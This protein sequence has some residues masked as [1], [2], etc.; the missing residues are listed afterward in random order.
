MIPMEDEY[1]EKMFLGQIENPIAASGL[2]LTQAE[3]I[4][5]QMVEYK[6]MRMMY[7]CALKE[8]RTKFDV[9]NTEFGVRYQRNPIEFIT[10]RVKS[11]HS[12]FEKMRRQNQTFTMNSLEENISDIAGIR[13]IC[14]YVDDIYMLAQALLAQ[15]DITLLREKDYISH[16]KD[17]GYRSLHLIV[18]V[19]VFFTDRKKDM[20][21]E[22]QIRTIA[23]DFWASLEH[24]IKYKKN[25]P[26]QQEIVERLKN[27]AE[28]IAETDMTMLDIR[29]EME[30]DDIREK[31]EQSGRTNMEILLEKLKRL[32]EPIV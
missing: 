1:V 2:S 7:T 14:S 16:P 23:M 13:V 21:V 18:S 26:N 31:R 8:I 15:D 5:D 25:V 9:L 20:K 29:R 10:M 30:D 12:I 28:V 17:N 22:V 24:G 3:R 4:I 11:T 6:K 32:D 19:P 27:C